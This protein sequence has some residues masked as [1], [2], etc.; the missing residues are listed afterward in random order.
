MDRE[1]WKHLMRHPNQGVELTE[2]EIAEGWHFCYAWDG[3]LVEPNSP[4]GACC[5]CVHDA[6]IAP[7][8]ERAKRGGGSSEQG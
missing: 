2:A 1:R 5:E 3:L 6:A 4:E 8:Y 7:L